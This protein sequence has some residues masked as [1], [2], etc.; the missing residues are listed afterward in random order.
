MGSE[1]AR[2]IHLPLEAYLS[3]GEFNCFSVDWEIGAGTI[4]YITARNRVGEVGAHVGKFLKNLIIL[5]H[6]SLFE[7]SSE[8]IDFLNLETNVP[9]SQVTV[10]G[11]SLGGHGKVLQLFLKKT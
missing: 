10:I 6:I 1:R 11:H 7:F 5:N 2:S 8:L 4:N 9:F 3:V